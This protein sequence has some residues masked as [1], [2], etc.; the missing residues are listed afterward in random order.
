AAWL[1]H[2]GNKPEEGTQI[3]LDA[4]LAA[5]LD[6]R[7]APEAE[8]AWYERAEVVQVLNEELERVEQ[9]LA[10]E[11]GT[12]LPQ[13]HSLFRLS[14]PEMDLL[15]TC[16]A[17]AIDPGLGMVYAYLQQYPARSYATESLAARLFGCGP[18]SM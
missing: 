2:L 8:A 10:G 11:S 15:Q 16:L 17:P 1:T 5:Y 14:V 12:R 4:N 9:A 18:R 3:E 13:L 7:D 6:G